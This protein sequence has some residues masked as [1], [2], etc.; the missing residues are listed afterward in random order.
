MVECLNVL[1][2]LSRDARRAVAVGIATA[3][4][5]LSAPL[6]CAAPEPFSSVSTAMITVGGVVT[7]NGSPVIWDQTLFYGSSIVTGQRSESTLDFGNLTRLKLDA[8]TALTLEFSRSSLSLSASLES[9]AV[10]GFIPTGTRVE[11]ITADASIASDPRQPAVFSVQ[12]ESCVTTVSVQTGRVEINTGNSVRAVIAGESFTTAHDSPTPA[13]P[14][15][16][17]GN[18]KRVGLF[19]GIGAALAVLVVAITGRGVKP[20]GG[21]PLGL[22]SGTRGAISLSSRTGNAIAISDVTGSGLCP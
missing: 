4:L 1:N 3:I 2:T 6:A 15:Q 8:E 13:A 18:N 12:V 5:N 9:G 16:D 11:I 10:R 7:I 14:Q 21:C 19:A 22:S 17:P 20:R